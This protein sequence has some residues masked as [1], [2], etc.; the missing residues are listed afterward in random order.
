MQE[1]CEVDDYNPNAGL[2]SAYS[3]KPRWL[4]SYRRNFGR[5]KVEEIMTDKE[6][7]EKHEL[8]LQDIICRSS[9]TVVIY[10]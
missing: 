8:E 10:R 5:A 1:I 2:F 4:R 6:K 7:R 9:Y 3:D